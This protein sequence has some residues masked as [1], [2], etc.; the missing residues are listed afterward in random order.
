[1]N[2]LDLVLLAIIGI[3]ALKGFS[4]GFIVE[5]C[6][7]LGLILGIWA[8]IHLNDRAA[9]GLGLDR[10]QEVLSFIVV[11]IAVLILAHFIG[12]GLTKVIDVAQLTLPNKI[13]GIVFGALRAAFV[14]SVLLNVLGAMEHRNWMPAKSTFAA[15]RLYRPLR[16]F[17]PLIVPALE[18]TKW[19]ERTL[20]E[21][22]D[23]VRRLD[24]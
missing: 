12:R 7:L 11:F 17:A 4:R 19:L 2:W 8:G 24:P 21:A 20:E 18:E 3:A 22:G 9:E 6:S 10:D 14:L 15:S 13:A 1:V 23:E 16:A 5:V